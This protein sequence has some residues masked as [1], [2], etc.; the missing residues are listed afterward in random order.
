MPGPRVP[1][2][3][4]IC[5]FFELFKIG[6]GPSSS[7]A[8]GPMLAAHRFM[9]VLADDP[10]GDGAARVQCLLY[11]SL[12]LTGPGHGTD[13]AVALGLLGHEPEEFD[14]AA[15]DKCL[16]ELD[17]CAS[18]PF[19]TR[20]L[21]FDRST[22]IALHPE[23]VMPGHPNALEFQALDAAGAVVLAECY[24]SIGGGTIIGRGASGAADSFPALA[25]DAV[26][27]PFAS[28]AELLSLCSGHGLSISE[29]VFANEAARYSA[30]R[31]RARV[32]AITAAMAACVSRGVT[33]GGTLPGHFAVQRRAPGLYDKLCARGQAN[34]HVF[35]E[36]MEAASAFAISVNEENAAFGRVV[37]APT[38]GAAGV[39]PAVLMA[40]RRV[41]A[42]WD[43]EATLRFFMAATAFGGLAKR[44]ASIS[45]AEVG[46]QGEVGV[47]AAMAAAGAAAALG[48]TDAQ[49]ENAAEIALEHHL[50]MTCDPAG[51]FV[52]IPCI[53]RNAIGATKALSAAMLALNGSGM[54]HVPFD[55]V[56]LTMKRTGMDMRMEY[57]ETSLGGLALSLAQAMC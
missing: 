15:A 19:G 11:G 56:V 44:N 48:G 42:A 23:T 35:P 7:H 40:L 22:G 9:Q 4:N 20:R 25:G 1:D 45:G 16:A 54:H 52:Q 47:A 36:L 31:V 24:L 17:K 51:G 10:A 6:I 8:M 30:G 55:T 53:E 5:S 2:V 43:D 26:P 49:V 41:N 18:I 29:L 28:A 3:E 46:C 33:T 14:P 57:K 37:T 13:R 27:Y 34:D 38:N 12:A 50:G 21:A 39:V 32:T